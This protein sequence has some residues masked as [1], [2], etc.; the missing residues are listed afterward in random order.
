MGRKK[1]SGR[2]TEAERDWISFAY[3]MKLPRAMAPAE[4]IEHVRRY[5]AGELRFKETGDEALRSALPKG[6]QLQW[7]WRNAPNK[8]LLTASLESV[9]SESRAGYLKLMLHRLERDLASLPQ[10][11]QREASEAVAKREQERRQRSEAAKLGWRR[12]RRLERMRKRAHAARKAA[13][14]RTG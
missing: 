11:A 9:V 6:L 8:P 2:R 10:K 1:K 5:I 4:A 3:Q 7:R 14:A 13:K 12:R